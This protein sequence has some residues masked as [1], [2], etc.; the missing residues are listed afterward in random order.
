MAEFRSALAGH[1]HEGRQF[2]GDGPAPIILSEVTGCHIVQIATWPDQQARLGE[3]LQA[4][5]DIQLATDPHLAH[6]R[7][8]VTSF[9][10]AP[11][12]YWLVGAFDSALAESLT[13]NCAHDEACITDLSHSQT[14][15]FVEGPRA[16]ELLNRGIPVDLHPDKFPPGAF[17]RT[18]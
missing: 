4:D 1:F 10:V 16:R 3:K 11:A 6:T 9:M 12:R 15:I 2:D 13:E 5:L 14:I 18:S 7:H 8:T 17:D